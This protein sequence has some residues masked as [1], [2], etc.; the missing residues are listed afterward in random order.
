M[1]KFDVLKKYYGFDSFKAG[2]EGIIDALLAGRDVVAVMPTGAGKSLCYQ[3]PAMLLPGVTIVVSPLISLMQDQVAALNEAGIQAGFVNSS[4]SDRQILDVYDAA[5]SGNIKILYVAPERLESHAFL[6]FAGRLEIS[7]V[8][9]DEAHCISQWGQ[10]FRPSYLQIV[11]FIKYIDKCIERSSADHGRC[12]DGLDGCSAEHGRCRVGAFTATATEEVRNDIVRVLGMKEPKIV[13]TGFERDNLDFDVV[14][15]GKTKEKIKYLLGFVREHEAESGI[16]YCAT[17][18]NVE[19]VFDA[20]TKTGVAAA[21][22]HAGMDACDR[23]RNQDDFI[24][25]RAQVIVATNAFGM[26]IDK[27]NVRFVVHFNMPESMENYYQE[28]GRAG[29]DGEH[30]RCVLLFSAQDIMIDRYLIAHKDFDDVPVDEVEVLKG[31]DLRRLRVMEE[32][33]RTQ[34]CLRNFILSYFG[35]VREE[36][37][38]RCGGCRREYVTVD[39]TRE[40][41]MVV[42]CVCEA[43]GRYGQNVLVGTLRGLD[44][45]RLRQLGTTRYKTFGALSGCSEVVLK[46]LIGQMVQDGYLYKTPDKYSMVRIRYSAPLE[47]GKTRVLV[48]VPADEVAKPVGAH[49]NSGAAEQ[50]GKKKVRKAAESLTGESRELFETLRKLRLKISN[51]EGKPPYIVFSD[52]T[53]VEMVDKKPLDKEAMLE[54]SGVGEKKLQKYGDRFIKAIAEFAPN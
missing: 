7:M 39:M 23:A 31:R 19:Q 32:Y 41:R 48:R 51:E 15:I 9:V 14:E 18:K 22:Y 13:A 28:A 20:L 43:R 52:K 11:D 34:G 17:R 33:C 25:D 35:E 16:I 46:A 2:Q 3:I 27:S 26:G 21:R 10:D 8:A 12:S 29:R 40:A 45:S 1:N 54:V 49:N 38:G 37:C 36:P 4:L 47:D 5:L 42:L 6:S 44:R 24:F 53:L 30:A 50:P